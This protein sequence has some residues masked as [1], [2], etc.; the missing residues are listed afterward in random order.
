MII[1]SHNSWS[2]LA[3]KKLWMKTLAFTAKCQRKTI[4][5]QYDIYGVRCFDLRVR[6]IDNVPHVVH[7]DFDYGSFASIEKDIVWL[8]EKG[9]V[10]IR[11]LHDVRQKKEYKEND[12]QRFCSFCEKLELTYTRIAFWCG[13]NLYNWQVDY[14]FQFDP[15]CVEKYS[16]VCPPKIID[17]W[18]PIIYAKIHNKEI[19]EEWSNLGKDDILLIDFVDI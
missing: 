12:V 1:G 17:D 2:Y 16:S 11:V 14:R 4:R 18:L 10:V 3:P 8:N 9:D 13:R 5:E 7:N 19:R 15:I 6:F